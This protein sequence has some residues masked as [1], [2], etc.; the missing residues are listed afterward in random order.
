MKSEKMKLEEL[1]E[2]KQGDTVSDQVD[3]K[4]NEAM[5]DEHDPEIED[6]ATAIKKALGVLEEESLKSMRQ[7]LEETRKVAKVWEM[8][9]FSSARSS[10]RS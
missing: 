7:A 9:I 1:L 4:I 5:G 10:Q 6:V 8:I 2:S 3:R